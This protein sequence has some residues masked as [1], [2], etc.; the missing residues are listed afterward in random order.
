MIDAQNLYDLALH[1][2]G[3]DV[4]RPWNDEF[5][6]AGDAARPPHMRV[7]REQM[8]HV[9][10]D[11]QYNPASASGAFLGDVG[12]QRNQVLDRLGRPDDVH[13]AFGTGRSRLRPQELTQT[14]TSWCVTP[15]PR[16][17]AAIARLTPAT[18]H[19]FTS[20]YALSAS[21][22]RN[23][24][25]RPV[26]LASFSKRFLTSRSTR[27]VKVVGGIVSILGIRLCT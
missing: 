24:R 7:A 13:V 9:A 21:A 16:S 1:A 26:L 20:R 15:S 11:A 12:S 25:V 18:C 5:A 22:A 23:E 27:T 8:F 3:D 2:I 6:G 4:R 19:S 14:L 17:S 10:Q